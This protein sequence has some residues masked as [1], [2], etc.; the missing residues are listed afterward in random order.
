MNNVYLTILGIGIIGAAVAIAIIKEIVETRKNLTEK[1]N[2]SQ[3]NLFKALKEINP[4]I[5]PPMSISVKEKPKGEVYNPN[6][7]PM[8][9]MSGNK[10]EMF[11]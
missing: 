4:N 10:V 7:D 1:L 11:D 8:E 6:K 3:N 2:Q 9:V 5:K